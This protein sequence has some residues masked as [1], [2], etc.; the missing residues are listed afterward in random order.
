LLLVVSWVIFVALNLLP[1]TKKYYDM[2]LVIYPT[3]AQ[4]ALLAQI[5]QLAA[6]DL[7]FKNVDSSHSAFLRLQEVIAAQAAH[8]GII[9]GCGYDSTLSGMDFVEFEL[10]YNP[11][12]GEVYSF[13][14]WGFESLAR[15]QDA[16]ARWGVQP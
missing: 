2:S 16:K 4:A 3:A 12:S 5:A 10:R 14:R 8:P 6:V 7:Q 9:K 13:E 11:D 1:L 15:H